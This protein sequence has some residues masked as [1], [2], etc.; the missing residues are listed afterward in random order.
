MSRTKTYYNVTR[1]QK[2][3]NKKNTILVRTGS[4]RF[5][6]GIPAKNYEILV[7]TGT[8]TRDSSIKISE[9][10]IKLCLCLCLTIILM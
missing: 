7:G 9:L 1:K 2:D 5:F 3:N 4:L 6:Q 10:C 8:G